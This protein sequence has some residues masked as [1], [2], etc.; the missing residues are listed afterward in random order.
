MRETDERPRRFTQRQERDTE[1]EESSAR[2]A[3]GRE[4]GRFR[5]EEEQPPRRSFTQRKSLRERELEEE[6]EDLRRSGR[7]APSGRRGHTERNMRDSEDY[8]EDYSE[9]EDELERKKAPLLVRLFAWAALLV[10]FFVCGYFGANYFF[11]WADKRGGPKVGDVVGSAADVRQ[12][13]QVEVSADSDN[14]NVNY[15][16]YVPDGKSFKERDAAIK[17]GIP[18]SDMDKVLSMYL[19]GLKEINMLDDS[20]KTLNLFRSDDTL[21][22]DLTGSFR[23][24]LGKLGADKGASVIDGIVRT[25]KENFSPVAKVKFYIDGKEPKDKQPVDLTKVWGDNG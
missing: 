15:K 13:Q 11:N 2:R 21:Y 4:R 7:N 9:D 22:L 3:G 20:V 10:I 12:N 23:T 18:E 19:D 24:S 17:K 25:M 14:G 8:E 16:I 6:E 1:R 5:D